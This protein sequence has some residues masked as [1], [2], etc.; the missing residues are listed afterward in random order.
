MI[1]RKQMIVDQQVERQLAAGV[2][3]I[4]EGALLCAVLED[5]VEKVLVVAEVDGSETIAGFAILPYNNPATATA[6]EQ[7]VVPSSGSLIFSL[8]NPRVVSDSELA[9]VVGGSALTIDESSFSST[10]STGTVKVDILGG[11]IKF[12]AGDAGKV[13]NFLY[14][15]ELTVTQRNIRFQERSINNRDVVQA[16][17][18]VGIAKGY[19]EIATDQFDSSKDYAAA[20]SLKLGDN[21]LVSDQSAAGP[22]IPQ[23]RVLALPDMTDT[24]QGAFLKISA[25]IG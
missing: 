8:R 16:L 5:G 20:T 4:Q 11:R 15:Y 18:Q 14:R 24:A 9:K 23:G 2:N 17:R 3:D 13:V 10:P 12:A 7:F 19:V 6:Q 1:N 21:G 22:V 25:L